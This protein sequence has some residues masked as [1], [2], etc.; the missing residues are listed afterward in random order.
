MCV[1]GGHEDQMNLHSYKVQEETVPYH[2]GH[3]SWDITPLE[4][5]E[6]LS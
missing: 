2:G 1:Q 4:Q 6:I 3:V 5:T